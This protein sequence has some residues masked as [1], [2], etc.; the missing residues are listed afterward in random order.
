MKTL[1]EKIGPPLEFIGM[2]IPMITS[3]GVGFY[4]AYSGNNIEDNALPLEIAIGATLGSVPLAIIGEKMNA[5]NA[6][7]DKMVGT[8][9]IGTTIYSPIC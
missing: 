8:V 3:L 1:E 7:D 6:F 4:Y 2:L 9:A 5:K